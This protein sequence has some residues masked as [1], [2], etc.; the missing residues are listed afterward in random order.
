MVEFAAPLN[1][2]KTLLV[3]LIRCMRTRFHRPTSVA[4]PAAIISSTTICGRSPLWSMRCRLRHERSR[5]ALTER[6]FEAN[7][8]DAGTSTEGWREPTHESRG[9]PRLLI[10]STDRKGLHTSRGRL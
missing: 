9:K 3:P 7:Q 6:K 10:A 1:S 4:C 2:K 5:R 8:R